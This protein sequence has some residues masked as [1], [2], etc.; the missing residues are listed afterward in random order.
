MTP[1]EH[2]RRNEIAHTMLHPAVGNSEISMIYEFA[3]K[4]MKYEDEL[5]KA[6]QP[7]PAVNAVPQNF[8][9]GK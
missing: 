7:K 2:K 3:N 6:D 1:E 4:V 8:K 5:L 9:K